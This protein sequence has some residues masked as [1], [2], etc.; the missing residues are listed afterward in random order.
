MTRLT[1]YLRFPP[2]RAPVI[3]PNGE[4]NYS[5]S[6]VYQRRKNFRT[7]MRDLFPNVFLSLIPL[8]RRHILLLRPGDRTRL[9]IFTPIVRDCRRF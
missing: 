3:Y 7:F 6:L 1:T 8:G 2:R 5:P 4:G 9:F